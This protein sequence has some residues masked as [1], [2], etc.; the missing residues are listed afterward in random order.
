MAF[1]IVH[2]E[3]AWGNLAPSFTLEL[4]A[5]FAVDLVGITI[6]LLTS[7]T[8]SSTGTTPA[9]NTMYYNAIV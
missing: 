8:L 4:I 5:Y 1:V 9:C 6:P 7:A 3:G 2:L